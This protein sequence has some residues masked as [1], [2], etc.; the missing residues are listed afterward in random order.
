[1]VEYEVEDLMEGAGGLRATNRTSGVA[2]E[3]LRTGLRGMREWSPETKA[4]LAAAWGVRVDE[5]RWPEVSRERTVRVAGQKIP[6]YAT[7][8]VR[9]EALPAA[10]AA[11]TKDHRNLRGEELR[12]FLSDEYGVELSTH[13]EAKREAEA[14]ADKPR[15]EGGFY[16][17]A[18]F[19]AAVAVAISHRVE[20]KQ[21][22]IAE[23]QGE[24][25]DDLD[26]LKRV[27]QE[28]QRK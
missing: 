28:V 4:K 1:V 10:P 12:R 9:G 27:M 5:V 2:L 13:G 21:R 24:V 18:Q 6:T 3:T 14:A 11:S 7:A 20:D 17:D 16:R 8:E 23:L 25:T 26:M 15:E 19:F 22:R